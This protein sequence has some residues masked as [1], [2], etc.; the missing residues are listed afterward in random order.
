MHAVQASA[1]LSAR[2]KDDAL[3]E[4]GHQI[5]TGQHVKENLPPGVRLNTGQEQ[6]SPVFFSSKKLA[7]FGDSHVLRNVTRIH[8]LVLKFVLQ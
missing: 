4:F 5:S 6:E 2:K 7:L 3:F 8:D 1:Q